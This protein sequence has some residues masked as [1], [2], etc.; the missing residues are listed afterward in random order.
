MVSTKNRV[1]MSK[2]R[3]SL[4]GPSA[5]VLEGRYSEQMGFCASDAGSIPARYCA[6]RTLRALGV[7]NRKA[8]LFTFDHGLFYCEEAS[9]NYAFSPFYI[10]L[11]TSFAHPVLLSP[12]RY[13][14]Y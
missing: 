2:L 1:G 6:Y 13:T 11:D 5:S 7:Y 12:Y 10:S 3:L 9:F 14:S 4:S 8:S